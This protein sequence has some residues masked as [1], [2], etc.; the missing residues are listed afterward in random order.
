MSVQEGKFAFFVAREA[1][2]LVGKII[3]ESVGDEVERGVDLHWLRPT[4]KH[5]RDN[6]ALLT[7]QQYWKRFFC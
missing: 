1:P 3:S 2:S 7:L 6:A 4:N 5:T